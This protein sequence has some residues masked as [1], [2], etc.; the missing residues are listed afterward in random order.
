MVGAVLQGGWRFCMHLPLLINS[1]AEQAVPH[2]LQSS[3]ALKGRLELTFSVPEQGGCVT[4]Q[5][6]PS[7]WHSRDTVLPCSVTQLSPGSSVLSLGTA[8]STK[9]LP[10][11]WKCFFLITSVCPVPLNRFPTRCS[12]CIYPPGCW[13]EGGGV[14][15]LKRLMELQSLSP[16]AP[17]SAL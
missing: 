16:D 11:K 17:S 13:Q 7:H 9:M 3:R 8:A 14:G 2:F 15:Q 5:P 1:R 12:S 10:G 6:L 4:L